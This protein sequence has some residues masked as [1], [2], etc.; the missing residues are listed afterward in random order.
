MKFLLIIIAIFSYSNLYADQ[1]VNLS[2]TYKLGAGVVHFKQLNC[3]TVERETYLNGEA[4]GDKSLLQISD[5]W[6][7]IKVDDEYEVLTNHQ[8]WMWNRNKS[9]II[10][11]YV[12][13][14]ITKSDSSRDFMSGSDIYEL[15]NQ[16]I[17]KSSVF[18]RRKENSEGIIEINAD[19]KTEQLEKLE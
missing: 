14:T 15:T 5:A 6:D 12:V 19:N 16:N 8:R 11:E 10:H 9:K 4:M 17:K 7:I 3:N 18:L 1:C 2:H 13:D